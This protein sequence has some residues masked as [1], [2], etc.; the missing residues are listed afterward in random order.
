MRKEHKEFHGAEAP[1]SPGPGPSS[2]R[3]EDAGFDMQGPETQELG[4]TPRW[5][6]QDT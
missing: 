4:E 3:S 1:P 6:E 2:Q 5:P